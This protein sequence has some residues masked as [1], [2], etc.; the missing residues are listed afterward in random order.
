MKEKKI[1]TILGI[2][3]ALFVILLTCDNNFRLLLISMISILVFVIAVIRIYLNKIKVKKNIYIDEITGA[4]TLSRFKIEVEKQIKKDKNKQFQ[5][6]K[7]DIVNYKAI[8]ETFG[9]EISENLIKTAVEALKKINKS[10]L[11][12]RDFNSEIFALV[13]D[14]KLNDIYKFKNEFENHFKIIIRDY[15]IKDITFRYARYFIDNNDSV[16]SIISKVNM[17]H[18]FTK[19]EEGANIS[20]YTDELKENLIR[21]TEITNKMQDAINNKDFKILLQPQFRLSDMQV[22]AAEVLVRW[23]DGEKIIFPNEFIPVFEKNG[24]IIQLDKYML[25]ESCVLIR[26]WL[27][28]GKKC[29]PI[30]INFSRLNI[31]N[32][33]F[34]NDVKNII[35]KECIPVKYIEIE[36]TETLIAENENKLKRMFN[37]LADEGIAIAI[38]DFGTAQSSL[39]MLRNYNANI[40]KL[41]KSFFISDGSDRKGSIVVKSVINLAHDLNMKT[42]AEGI[43]DA[44]LAEFLKEIGCYAAQGY[45]FS[46]PITPEEF[47]KKYL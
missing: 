26:N 3:L 36:I 31:K 38:D 17:A 41:D 33:N 46:K 13:K 18:N 44:D 6:I 20:D 14:E 25:R 9:E 19:D 43:E 34:I 37:R 35:N 2:A 29:V 30:A 8:K 15:K 23:Q 7:I 39:S 16:K 4:L 42:V 24:F 47:A 28:E 5:M 12:S 10:M 22:V 21:Q 32:N 27:D 45:L 11:I 1:Y 40:L